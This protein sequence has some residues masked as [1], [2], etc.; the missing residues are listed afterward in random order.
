MRLLSGRNGHGSML[1]DTLDEI[2]EEREDTAAPLDATERALV[3]NILTLRE[4]TAED[5]MTPRADIVAVSVDT[6]LAE[7][8]ERM[9]RTGHSRLPVYREAL[10]DAI[11]FVHVKDVLAWRGP[12]EQF[13]LLGIVRP[14]LFVAPSIGIL[15]LLV[16]MRLQRTHLALVVDEF[17]GVDGLI[18][19][20]DLIE[21][22]VG[23]I[24]DEHDR[25]DV[26]PLV[27]VRPDGTIDADGRASI[28]EIDQHFG[29]LIDDETRD[30]VDT[31][32]GLV[33][34]LAGRVARPG[35]RVEHPSG[36]AFEVLDADP[37]RVKR[38]RMQ[39]HPRAG[40]GNGGAT[41][42]DG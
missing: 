32:G 35:E 31:I 24:V 9:T 4:L 29:P 6:P 22:I 27:I 3:A 14:L 20:E 26:V 40:N 38:V 19:L 33:V 36:L 30:E 28:D 12:A 37:R 13:R 11:G 10:D 34:H 41:A 39:F 15:R 2:I 42:G 16:D 23:E 18:T 17:G 8:V 21:E 5:V 25:R 7:V 1:R